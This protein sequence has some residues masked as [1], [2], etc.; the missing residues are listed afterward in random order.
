MS[1]DDVARFGSDPATTFRTNLSVLEE[2]INAACERAGRSR[3]SVRLL[4]ITK[5]VPA[6][7]LRVAWT[8]G[9]EAFGENKVQE[10]IAKYETLAD[11]PVTWSIVGHLQTNKAKYLTRFASEFYALDNLRVAKALNT[12]L[13]RDNQSLDVYVQVNTSGEIGKFGLSPDEL[14]PFLDILSLFTRL[15]PR[16]LMTLAVL[17][18]DE[19]LVRPCFTKLRLLRDQAM[20][21]HPSIVELSMGMSG[22]YEIAIEEGA[23]VVRIGQAIFGQ[24]PTPPGTYWPGLGAST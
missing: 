1:S 2:R 18:S 21:L 12:Q 13:E 20:R 17:S 5:T 23:D 11:L 19:A 7:I 15:R 8:A 3:A 9:L 6:H 16:G 4:P 10:A 22:D 14:L 24:R